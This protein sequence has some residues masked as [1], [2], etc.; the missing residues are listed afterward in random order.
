MTMLAKKSSKHRIL[1]EFLIFFSLRIDKIEEL[2]KYA[3]KYNFIRK[4][5]FINATQVRKW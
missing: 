4:G 5:E 3:L 1:G 2:T